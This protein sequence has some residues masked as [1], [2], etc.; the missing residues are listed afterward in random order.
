MPT[1]ERML[2]IGDIVKSPQFAYI[3]HKI[4]RDVNGVYSVNQSAVPEIGIAHNPIIYYDNSG[5][6]HEIVHAEYRPELTDHKFAVIGISHMEYQDQPTFI[7]L[8]LTSRCQYTLHLAPH[9]R[10]SYMAET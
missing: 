1:K 9:I 8:D 4:E 7:L 5:I 10:F 6:K 2:T 3:T